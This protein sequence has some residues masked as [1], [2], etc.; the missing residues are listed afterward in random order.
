M[1]NLNLR[2][3]F[4]K[5][6]LFTIIL[7]TSMSD[8]ISCECFTGYKEVSRTDPFVYGYAFFGKGF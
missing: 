3:I 1:L 2:G 5:K 7:L 6:I 8:A 4:L